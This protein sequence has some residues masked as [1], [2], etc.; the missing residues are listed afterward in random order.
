MLLEQFTGV[1]A[2]TIDTDRKAIQLIIAKSL[3]AVDFDTEKLT[4]ETTGNKGNTHL[5]DYPLKVLAEMSASL[6]GA[7]LH[8]D[9]YLAFP[10]M[11][12][13][14]GFQLEDGQQLSIKL[15]D[16]DATATY[17]LYL[18]ESITDLHDPVMYGRLTIETVRNE[19]EFS[20]V[21]IETVALPVT[22]LS[23]VEFKFAGNNRQQFTAEELQ[24]A[25]ITSND[26]VAVNR[27]TMTATYGYGDYLILPA[28]AATSMLI[29]LS[30]ATGYEA[31]YI[32]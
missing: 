22:N 29:K 16:L 19:K 14:T 11:L 27:D 6:E 8:N 1:T 21:G 4:I 3:T 26:T 24:I 7:Y 5:S 23:E 9:D 32:K 25:L 20:L 18:V 31:F 10:V 12:A 17:S 30:A 15:K 13:A 2:K 28:G